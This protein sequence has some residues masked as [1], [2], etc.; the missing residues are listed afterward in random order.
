MSKGKNR[1]SNRVSALPTE[2]KSPP[3]ARPAA[4][5]AAQKATQKAGPQK[6]AAS[7]SAPVKAG[8]R[9][10]QAAAAGPDNRVVIGVLVGIV[11]LAVA[12]AL[13]LRPGGL[14]GAAPQS[15][16]PASSALPAEISVADAKARYDA[17][18]FLLDVREPDEWA[19]VHIPNTTLI[20]L[21][22]LESRT[23]ELPQDQEIVVICRSGNRSAE[24]RDKLLA[25]GFAQV[26][27][28]AG[29]MNEWSAAGYPTVSGQ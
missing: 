21:G 29:G 28:V 26:T 11:V 15:A 10:D 13:I 2:K 27:S 8:A 1:S 18:D 14:T 16:A 3:P 7:K 9:K 23:G 24:A 4:Q 20:P 17:G 12:L 6:S 22:E 5:K 19:T 25:A